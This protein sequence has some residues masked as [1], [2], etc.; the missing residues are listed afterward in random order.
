[1]AKKKKIIVSD[2]KCDDCAF[3]EWFTAYWNLDLNGKPITLHCHL[4]PDNI[5]KGIIRGTASCNN[6]KPRQS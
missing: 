1:M 4:D 5:K 6:F 2:H 3:G